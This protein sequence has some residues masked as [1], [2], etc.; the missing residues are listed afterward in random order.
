MSPDGGCGSNL[1]HSAADGVAATQVD[2][3]ALDLM[4][5]VCVLYVYRIMIVHIAVLE[6]TINHWPFSNQFQYLAGQNS[7]KVPIDFQSD[8]SVI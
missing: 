2:S 6:K 7:A 8:S 1:E 4:Y 5:V 3:Y